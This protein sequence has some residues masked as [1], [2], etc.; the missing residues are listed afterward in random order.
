MRDAQAGNLTN[1]VVF[2]RYKENLHDS[3]YEQLM[4]AIDKLGVPH[5]WRGT[6][7]PLRITYIPTGQAILFRG[8]DKVKKAKSIKVSKGYIR[9]LWFEELDEFENAEKIRS[10]Q[11]SVVR[12]GAQFT[13]F[14]TYNPPKSQRNWVNDPA[15][16]SKP[17]IID[18]HSTYLSL[19]LP[20]AIAGELARLVT[21]EMTSKVE[22][23]PRAKYLQGEYQ[24]VLDGIR[25]NAEVAAA[26]GGLVFKP[27]VDGGHIAVDC[28]PAWR[29]LP[30]AFNSRG[31][32]TGA[33][34]VELVQKGKT[35]YTRMEHHQLTDVGYTIRNLAFQSLT[36]S[37][38]GTQCDLA[39]VDEWADLEPELTIHYKDGTAP[40]GALFA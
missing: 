24:Q 26:G 21:V 8:A 5:L 6:V 37:A 22:G 29:F 15:Q 3:V 34:F 25:T 19:G 36:S 23:S 33:V 13:V 14:Y 16:W 4:W 39:S 2:R 28:V 32:V 11:Q 38:I 7:S 31:K 40:E 12:G 9:Y 10:I 35:F 27:Y 1:A 17:G 18:H 30:T 20:A